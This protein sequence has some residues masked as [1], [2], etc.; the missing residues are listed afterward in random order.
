MINLII[1]II[2]EKYISIISRTD[3]VLKS[4]GILDCF[5]SYLDMDP[6]TT[7]R[8]FFMLYYF[9]ISQKNHFWTPIF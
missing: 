3:R 2:L 5:S 7:N 6:M 9:I 4:Y 1:L 8:S